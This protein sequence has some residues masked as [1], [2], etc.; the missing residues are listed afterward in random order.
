M[1]KDSL[2]SIPRPLPAPLLERRARVSWKALHQEASMMSLQEPVLAGHLDAHITRR[3]CLE[4]SLASLLASKLAS[5]HVPAASLH[6]LFL[7]V[8][9]NS[10]ETVAAVRDDMLA[11]LERDPAVT[12]VA[13]LYLNQKGFQALQSHRVAHALWRQ[14]RRAMALHVQ[15]RASEVFAVD[16]HPAARM[17]SGVFIDHGTGVVIG[18][19]AVVGNDVSIL[20]DVTLGGTGK[21]AGDRHPKIEEGVLL[22]AGAKVLGNIRIGS[23]SK[24]GA[25]SVVL[26]D[27]PR[28]VTVAGVPAHIVGWPMHAQPGR[29]MSQSL[30]EASA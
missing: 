3:T 25:G 7:G 15:S 24:V 6:E 28:H 4:E 5:A 9:R 23:G 21:E 17:G 27:V 20:Q 29:E 12:G 14:G 2:I 19:T 16:I 26:K 18:E 11:A 30:D 22:C 1:L 10:A 13:C 8:Y